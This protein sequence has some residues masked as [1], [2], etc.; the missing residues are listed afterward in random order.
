MVRPEV[1]YGVTITGDITDHLHRRAAHPEPHPEPHGQ[2]EPPLG[3]PGVSRQM[4][5]GSYRSAG[6]WDKLG[7]W[8]SANAEWRVQVRFQAHVALND[9]G[10]SDGAV[11]T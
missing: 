3:E 11:V 7:P 9:L 5:T 4:V 1:S 8:R 2:G 10:P 6:R